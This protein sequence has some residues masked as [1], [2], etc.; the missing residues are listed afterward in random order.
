[1]L[2]IEGQSVVS[3]L[4][5]MSGHLILTTHAGDEIDAGYVLGDAVPATT[6][7]AGIAELATAAE[8]LAMT[9]GTRTVTPLGLVSLL[10]TKAATTHSHVWADITSGIPVASTTLQ[11]IVELATSAETSALTDTTRAVTPASLAT[12]AGTKSDTTHTH[13]LSTLT[14]TLSNSQLATMAANTIKGNNTGSTASPLDLTVAQV[15][16]MLD[17]G[18]TTWASM[19]LRG[20]T[21]NPTIGAGSTLTGQY[22]L[23]PN[24]TIDLDAALSVGSGWSNGSGDYYMVLPASRTVKDVKFAIGLGLVVPASGDE[25]PA[26]IAFDSSTRTRMFLSTEADGTFGS[27]Y[28]MV[29]GDGIRWNLRGIRLDP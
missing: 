4:V 25:S 12:L 5:N 9:D 10:A 1:M 17:T 28:T 21:T 6:T 16:T 23:Y 24:N 15:Q 26:G 19:Q 29:S 14:G 27:T 3:G 20:T 7:V 22:R 8:T 2:T 18:W 11:G 13:A